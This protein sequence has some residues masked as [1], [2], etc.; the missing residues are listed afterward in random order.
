MSGNLKRK[1]NVRKKKIRI[2]VAMHNHGNFLRNLKCQSPVE[3]EVGAVALGVLGVGLVEL[4]PL[5]DFEPELEH[6]IDVGCD[7]MD[8]ANG[9]AR[10]VDACSLKGM[11]A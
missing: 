1:S 10:M 9:S 2:K 7:W 5:G 3:L 4:E 6:K 8:G 11:C